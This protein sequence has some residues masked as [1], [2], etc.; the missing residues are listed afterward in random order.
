MSQKDYAQ[1]KAALLAK[2]L[3]IYNKLSD[4]QQ[5]VAMIVVAMHLPMPGGGAGLQ[6]TD[7]PGMSVETFGHW[8]QQPYDATTVT[9]GGNPSGPSALPVAQYNVL[10]AQMKALRNPEGGGDSVGEGG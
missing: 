8:D 10:A 1:R 3:P 9:F 6:I 5:Q 4:P 7:F 2:V